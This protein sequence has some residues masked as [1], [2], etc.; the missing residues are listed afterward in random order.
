V[1]V[2]A[3]APRTG[4]VKTRLG[5]EPSA[6][7][8]VHSALVRSTLRAVSLLADE[9]DVELSTDLPASG[10][11]SPGVRHTVQA[12]GDLGNRI[13]EAIAGALRSGRPRAMVLGS[14][15][16]G[17]PA[18]HLRALL[19]SPADVALGP[20]EDGGFYAVGCRKAAPSM[21]D[22]VRWSTA[23]TLGDTLAALY[24]AGLTCESGPCWF[25][26]DRPE[27]L[28]RWLAM[29]SDPFR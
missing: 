8:E 21:F 10:W 28:R 24:R 6:A 22:G 4:E 25:D 1:I 17:L 13:Y 23:H 27:D 19:A 12:A 14:D 11:P 18:G 5:L 2:F 26:V 20:T 7:L 16:P 9:V 15:S 3:K 29:R